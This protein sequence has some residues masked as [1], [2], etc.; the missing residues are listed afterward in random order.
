MV[1]VAVKELIE[2]SDEIVKYIN[3]TIM[4]DYDGFVDSGKQYYED[5]A[6]VN[7]IVSQFYDMSDQIKEIVDNI[8]KTVDGI[9]VAMEGNAGRIADA[10]QNVN[11]LSKDIDA[12]AIEMDDNQTVATMLQKETE[13]FV[14]L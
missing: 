12:I 11:D 13:R 4:Q 2:S 14:K 9:A 5:A 3:E 6:Y 10:T 1:V 7:G 8:A